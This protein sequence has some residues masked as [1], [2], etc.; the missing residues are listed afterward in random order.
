MEIVDIVDANDNVIGSAAKEEV[1][2]KGL[3]SR[4]AFILLLN[5]QHE[6]F[7]Q[8]RKSTKKTYP[9]YWSGSAAGHVRSGE[10]YH[11]AALRELEEELGVKVNLTEVGTFTSDTD[12]E[13][14]TVF[15]GACEGPYTLEEAAIEKAEYYSLERLRKEART[16]QM[17]SYL[18]AALPMVETFLNQTS[19]L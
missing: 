6:L 8:Q 11:E 9:L 7:L 13:I 16:L 4:V 18:K 17:T 14:V 1:R 12:K 10:T 5:T 15:I 2:Q 3:L 19:A